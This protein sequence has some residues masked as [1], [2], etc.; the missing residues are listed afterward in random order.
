[1][2][3]QERMYDKEEL[4]LK[5]IACYG[6]Y[7]R[8]E[9]NMLRPYWTFSQFAVVRRE[10]E[11]CVNVMTGKEYIEASSDMPLV[12]LG[13]ERAFSPVYE[14]V[15]YDILLKEN[16]NSLSDIKKAM[17]D[18]SLYFGEDLS[19]RVQMGRFIKSLKR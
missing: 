18:S 15:R 19:W 14:G 8:G 7:D 12:A 3:N 10:K 13:E 9:G 4:Q 17:M 5:L 6:G 11:G 1:M 2:M 16:N